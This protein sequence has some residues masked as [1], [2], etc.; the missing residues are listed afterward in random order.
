[1]A[2]RG[3]VLGRRRAVN[4]PGAPQTTPATP[5]IGNL[6]YMPVTNRS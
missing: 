2:R 1:M 4:I 5:I 6:P 3:Q